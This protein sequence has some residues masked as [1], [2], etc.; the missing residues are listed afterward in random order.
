MKKVLI[1]IV[2]LA[3]SANSRVDSASNA[4][5]VDVANLAT[6]GDGSATNPYSGWENLKPLPE[7]E[8]YF[9][10][11]KTFEYFHSPNWL[12]PGIALRG[13]AG[14]T[15]KYGGNGDAFIMDN[16]GG[17][18]PSSRNWTKNVRVENLIIQGNTNTKNGMFLRGIRDGLFRHISIRDVSGAALYT[19][20]LVTN[21]FENVRC[22]RGEMPNA[23]FYVTPRYGAV[24]GT[25]GVSDS[26]TTTTFI[27]PVFEGTSVAGIYIMTGCQ[28]NTFINGT[29]ENNTGRGM[30]IDGFYNVFQNMDFETN[31]IEDVNITVGRNQ[32]LNCLSTGTVNI[33]KNAQQTVILGGKYNSITIDGSSL[34]TSLIAVNYASL[35]D[36][37]KTA[38]LIGNVAAGSS[39]YSTFANNYLPRVVKIPF[40]EIINTDAARSSFFNIEPL[41]SDFTLAN[42]T[43]PA[44]GQTVVWRF[45]QDAIGGRK[46]TYGDKFRMLYGGSLPTLASAPNAEDRVVATYNL[47]N[48]SWD[49]LESGNSGSDSSSIYIS[50]SADDK[51]N[52]TWPFTAQTKAQRATTI[53]THPISTIVLT[54]LTNGASGQIIV[55]QDSVGGRTVALQAGSIVEGGGGGIV[56]L[57][58]SPNAIDILSF[59]YDG[60]NLLWEKRANFN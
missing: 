53:L 38:I 26:T 21:V 5:V 33:N 44:D 49:V 29:C 15:L 43:N 25:R 56:T 8:Y 23:T 37:S 16:P 54:G 57:S 45:R 52:I 55:R 40:A 19:E 36:A 11:G 46:I 30:Q 3:A 14:T 41:K 47:R 35:A 9:R 17:E 27:N 48:E 60:K 28:N 10:E 31:S 6:E 39:V 2:V 24:L 1:A 12:V 4:K 20:G 32:F 59:T 58:A 34:L 7:T 51:G 13:G 50:L 22:I 18:R 42:P